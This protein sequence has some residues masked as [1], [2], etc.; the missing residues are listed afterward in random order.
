MAVAAAQRAATPPASAS[1]RTALA[2]VVT[3]VSGL[4]DRHVP[5]SS[6]TTVHAESSSR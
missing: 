6:V 2:G 1:E 4:R 5:G 3:V